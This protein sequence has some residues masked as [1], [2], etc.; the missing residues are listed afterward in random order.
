[1]R[2]II[3]AIA[4]TAS[5]LAAAGPLNPP[6]GPVQETGRFGPRTDV[7]TLPAVG[8]TVPGLHLIDKPGSYYLSDNIFVPPGRSGVVIAADNVTLNLN[9]FAI[10]GEKGSEHG[11]TVGL[12]DDGSEGVFKNLEIINGAICGVGKDGVRLS[13]AIDPFDVLSTASRVADLRIA[14]VGGIGVNLDFSSHC[15]VENVLVEQAVQGGISAG[16]YARV[17]DC[18]TNNCFGLGIG[19][20]SGSRI[21][22][23]VSNLNQ[24]AGGIAASTSVIE[25]CV[26]NFNSGY[27]VNA[28]N[29]LVRGCVSAN[30]TGAEI[31][32]AGVNAIDNQVI[33]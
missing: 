14:D 18:T 8:G 25:G 29:G 7:Q 12:R 20:G 33:P 15:A 6:A 4:L 32:G 13:G 3:A 30:N 5:T 17:R 10:L 24:N 28:P 31:T 23:C 2:R 27:G 22:D 9:G 21:E 26:T 1:M 11:V 16:S 19:A